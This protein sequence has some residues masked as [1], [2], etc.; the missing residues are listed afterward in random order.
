MKKTYFMNFFLSRDFCVA[1]ERATRGLFILSLKIQKQ[2]TALVVPVIPL[3]SSI[4]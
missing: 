3:N 1:A 4:G 2:H